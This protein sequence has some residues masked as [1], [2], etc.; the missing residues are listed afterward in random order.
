MAPRWGRPIAAAALTALLAGTVGGAHAK[1]E[2]SYPCHPAPPPLA[3]VP[4]SAIVGYIA[5]A[6]GPYD[7]VCRREALLP[8]NPEPGTLRVADSSGHTVITLSVGKRQTFAIPISPG[9]YRLSATLPPTGGKAIPIPCLRT[10]PRHPLSGSSG[11]LRVLAGHRARVLCV[12]P[13]P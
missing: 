8:V 12:F 4:G 6:G 7:L 2:R 3:A 9:T 13:V 11:P 1:P 5:S 10:S